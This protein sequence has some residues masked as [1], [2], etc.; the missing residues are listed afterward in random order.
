MTL[1]EIIKEYSDDYFILHDNTKKNIE[2]L[3]SLLSD[4]YR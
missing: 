1:E 4:E 3:L 2:K